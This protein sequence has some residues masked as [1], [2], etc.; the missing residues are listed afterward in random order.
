VLT[1]WILDIVYPSRLDTAN[2]FPHLVITEFQIRNIKIV[3]GDEND[4]LSQNINSLQDIELSYDQNY[5]T[6]FF[7]TLDY[8]NKQK[9][10]YAYFLENFDKNWNNI[11]QIRNV[12]EHTAGSVHAEHKIF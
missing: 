8:W 12:H 2:Y 5:F 7:T 1:D 9:S 10:E 3:P 4:I 6:F 11:G